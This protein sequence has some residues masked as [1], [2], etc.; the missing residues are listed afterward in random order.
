MNT[1][2]LNIFF[3][4]GPKWLYY[5]FIFYKCTLHIIANIHELFHIFRNQKKKRERIWIVPDFCFEKKP[6]RTS[7]TPCRKAPA[8]VQADPFGRFLP[9]NAVSHTS[10]D[11]SV[12]PISRKPDAKLGEVRGIL[13]LQHVELRQS[14]PTQNPTRSPRILPHPHYFRAKCRTFPPSSVDRHRPPPPFPP[15]RH[16][17][18]HRFVHT[19]VGAGEGG[20]KCGGRPEDQLGEPQR[21][22]PR[23]KEQGVSGFGGQLPITS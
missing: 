11:S 3:C 17:L 12:R 7:A 19:I 20:S 23:P 5:W 16:P 15:L 18:P 4:L 8:N 2:H 21:V 1:I 10:A 13:D 22:P 9:S 14:R 6:L